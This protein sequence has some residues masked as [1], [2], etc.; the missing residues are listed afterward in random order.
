MLL[1]TPV[2]GWMVDYFDRVVAL[3]I[4][5]GIAFVGYLALGIVEDPLNSP[6]AYLAAVLGG[7]GEAAVVVSGPA[8]VGQ[9]AAPRV[10]GSIIGFVAFFGA[11]GVLINSKISG[12]LFD[13]WMY[14]APFVFMAGMNL[15]VCL[16]AIAM[17]AWEIR[18][19][20]VTQPTAA[21]ALKANSAPGK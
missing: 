10:R 3:A 4:A 16:A 13:Q 12:V 17:R 19:G 18:T 14:Q 21:A 6:W 9:E 7:A 11:G 5:M 15:L 1:F 8:L 20:V 2:I